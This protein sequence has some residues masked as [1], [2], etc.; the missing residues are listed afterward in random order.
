MEHGGMK[1]TGGNRITRGKTCPSATLSAT[2]PTR[3][4]QSLTY[5][6]VYIY[7]LIHLFGYLCVCECMRSV[8]TKWCNFISNKTVKNRSHFRRVRKTAKSDY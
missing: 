5:V 2:N 6:Y 7:I 1:V 4:E 8:L 3:T